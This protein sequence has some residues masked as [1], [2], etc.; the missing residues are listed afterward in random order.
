MEM[1]DPGTSPTVEAIAGKDRTSRLFTKK[2]KSLVKDANAKQN[3]GK[4]LCENCKVETV[5]GEKHVKDVTPPSNE[6]Q[7]DHIIPKAKGGKGEPSNG[8]VLCRD[9]NIKK[10]DKPE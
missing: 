7:V 3:D 4:I 8:Q 9:C 10:S 6:A 5:P 1:G 2:G